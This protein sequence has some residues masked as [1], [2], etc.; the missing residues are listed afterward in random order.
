MTELTP[1]EIADYPLRTAVRGYRVE[2]VDDLLDRVA[3]RIEALQQETAE[4]RERLQ[5]AEERAAEASATEATLK[6]TLVTAQRAAE[7]TVAEARTEAARIRSDAQE[8]ADDLL[9]Q[10]R[11]EADELRTSATEELARAQE[12]VHAMRQD[13][14]R[15]VASLREAADRFRA[16]MRDHLDAHR[17]LL[18]RAPAADDLPAPAASEPT[19]TEEAGQSPSQDSAL[20]GAN[21]P[22]ADA[23]EA[24]GDFP[25]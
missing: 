15:D 7:D 12:A 17:D 14:D 3:D 9:G 21:S 16:T 8:Q 22:A 23:W 2:Q 10:A 18:E 25:G 5:A 11:A 6:R 13:A 1:N 19:G 24:S 4:L 20:F